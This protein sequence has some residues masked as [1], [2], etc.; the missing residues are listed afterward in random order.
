MHTNVKVSKCLNTRK[1]VW[2]VL[3]QPNT[4]LQST[5]HFPLKQPCGLHGRGELIGIDGKGDTAMF[6]DVEADTRLLLFFLVSFVLP[7]RDTR[8]L[9]H[10]R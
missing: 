9:V 5:W 2:A 1:H 6:P 8:L 7:K 10:Q 4:L 3:T